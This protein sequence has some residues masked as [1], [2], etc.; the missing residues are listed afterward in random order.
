NMPNGLTVAP[1]QKT[2]VATGWFL[3]SKS[4][5]LPFALP[6][7]GERLKLFFNQRCAMLRCCRCV[8][9][10]AIIFI[11]TRCL[12]P[13]E[14]DSAKLFLYG[15][16]RATNSR[17]QRSRSRERCP[18]GTMFTLAP[19]PD[20]SG[21]EYAGDQSSEHS[22]P[23]NS[24]RHRMKRDYRGLTGLRLEKQEQERVSVHR[25]ASYAFRMTSHLGI[26]DDA[27]RTMRISVNAVV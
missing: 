12:A 3:V 17:W 13:V 16:M 18:A 25:P 8:W 2:G 10:P 9:L 23:A 21:T 1:A 15:K 14:T 4:L 19:G 22:T 11:G 6:E 7:A 20:S 5:T 24:P 27:V 26:A